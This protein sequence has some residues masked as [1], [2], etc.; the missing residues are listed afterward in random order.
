MHKIGQFGG[1][2]SRIL[3]PLLKTG[4]PLIKNVLKPLAKSVLIPLALTAL[5]S[6]TY[7]TIHKKRMISNREINNIMKMTKSFGG[8]GSLKNASAK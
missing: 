8:T 2:L 7:E 6:A 1:F 3:G 5:T 4:M